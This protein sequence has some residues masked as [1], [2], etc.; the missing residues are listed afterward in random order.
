MLAT[1]IIFWGV[2]GHNVPPYSAGLSAEDL[3]AQ[4]AQHTFSSRVGMV[5]AMAV[6]VLYT[7]WGMAISQIMEKVESGNNVLSKLQLIGAAFTT[8]IL[9]IPPAFWL[10]AAFR[11][12]RNPELTQLLYDT[13]WIIF[14]VGFS[15]TSMQYVAFGVCFLSDTRDVTLIPKWVSWFAIW[16]GFMFVI[17]G[18]MP[19]FHDGP[20]SRSGWINYWI[21]FSIF[22]YVM[23]AMCIVVLGALTKLEREDLEFEHQ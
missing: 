5:G 7:V 3:A 19:F 18:L 2:L 9:V 4:L 22:F 23:S 8:L 16:V 11:P 21:E 20:F 12:D 10:S 14:D 13:G 6:G 1:Y 15:L 17:L